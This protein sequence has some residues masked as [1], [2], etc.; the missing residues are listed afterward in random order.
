MGNRDGLDHHS[1]T[2]KIFTDVQVKHVA[3]SDV[4][5]AKSIAVESASRPQ[6]SRAMHDSG[7]A[8]VLSRKSLDR[9]GASSLDELVE[10]LSRVP[11]VS[12]AGLEQL[13]IDKL[14]FRTAGPKD[15]E[16]P[17]ETLHPKE[18]AALRAL[19]EANTFIGAWLQSRGWADRTRELRVGVRAGAVAW[20]DGANY[21][22]AHRK[23]LRQLERGLDGAG[24]WIATLVHEYCHDTDDSES[25][26]HGEVFYAKYH[27]WT[28][29][30]GAPL[31][32]A[33]LRLQAAYVRELRAARQ[34]AKRMLTKQLKGD[35]I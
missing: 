34:A 1:L 14:P 28:G 26:D 31:T 16:L 5:A 11:D 20:T 27:E 29:N 3:L 15:R 13:D 22:Y 2:A 4:L 33:A 35:E 7:E 17:R 10:R 21:I 6:L 30:P 24:Y 8:L 23:Y 9:L 25:H 19:D 18:M 12:R 32:R